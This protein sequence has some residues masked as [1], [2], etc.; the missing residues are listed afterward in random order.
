MPLFRNP[1]TGEVNNYEGNAALAASRA[2]YVPVGGGSVDVYT[3]AGRHTAVDIEDAASFDHSLPVV[4]VDPAQIEQQRYA[5]LE[6]E[7]LQE[8]HGGAGG[9]VG[10]FLE[11]GA[12]ALTLGGYGALNEAFGGDFEERAEA[13]PKAHVGGE[14]AGLLG[15]VLVPGGGEAAIGRAG[16]AGKALAKTPA[17]FVSGKAT[18]LAEHI[19]G[20]RGAAAGQALEGAAY[21]TG[22]TLSQA[23]I[24]D[25]QLT[26][27]A[28]FGEVGKNAL[29]GAGIGASGAALAKGL[30]KVGGRLERAGQGVDTPIL[31]IASSEGR[32]AT[33]SLAGTL[34]EVD[35]VAENS[36]AAIQG[37]AP[38][39]PFK[40]SLD[41]S[42]IPKGPLSLDDVD[43]T[44]ADIPLPVRPKAVDDLTDDAV[45]FVS[46]RTKADLQEVLD[47]GGDV[48]TAPAH[49]HKILKSVG[50]QVVDENSVMGALSKSE[51]KAIHRAYADA[52]EAVVF[53]RE[54]KTP[55]S[56]NKASRALDKY[57]DAVSGAAKK[58][59]MDVEA[60]LEVGRRSIVPASE[61][62]SK[63]ASSARRELARA[64]AAGVEA[65]AQ[66]YATP[67]TFNKPMKDFAP[68]IPPPTPKKPGLSDIPH[69]AVLGENLAAQRALAVEALGLK[70]GSLITAD[71]VRALL[72]KTPDEALIGLRR[73]DDY[74]DATRRTVEELGDARMLHRLDKS[75]EKL[76]EQIGD[77]T[78]GVKL[79]ELDRSVIATQMGSEALASAEFKTKVGERLHEMMTLTKVTT[80]K[81]P[82]GVTKKGVL[83]G[84]L[85]SA[86]ARAAA[87][88]GSRLGNQAA[89]GGIGGALLG[90]VGASTGFHVIRSLA[91]LVSG[92]SGRIKG[93]VGAVSRKGGKLMKASSKAVRPATV[94]AAWLIRESRWGYDPEGIKA[95]DAS[96]LRE[97]FRHRA[98]ELAKIAAN[99]AAAQ[100]KIHN[101]LTPLRKYAPGVADELEMLSISVPLYLADKMPK[102]P[103]NVMRWGK[104][105]W[106]PDDY[107]ILRWGEH[108]R[109]AVTPV[110]TFETMMETGYITPQAAEAVRTLHPQLFDKMQLE[111]FERADEL[112]TKLDHGGQVRVSLFFDVPVT[113]TMRP[114]FRAFMKERHALKAQTQAPTGPK[115]LGTSSGS[116]DAVDPYTGAQQLLK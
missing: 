62:A 36:L 70:K 43:Y 22:Q 95:P 89:G 98:E 33:R 82:K 47:A 66:P 44:S 23:Y 10:A 50:D 45:D 53:A 28:L 18:A 12:D 102:D 7:R 26:A 49:R 1:T 58:L 46:P 69:A 64:E 73:L 60:Q 79:S 116:A 31:D 30:A 11:G 75:V 39:R 71:A 74:I 21:A 103:G 19:G 3:P 84:L 41:E 59:G 9:Q 97:A 91:G 87:R 65:T 101:E 13:N 78:G 88:G 100:L 83:G 92:T 34:D 16:L 5:E 52:D 27:S 37:K 114:E 72:T 108:M 81:L 15:A 55:A 29:F 105:E 61:E 20:L 104:S 38:G 107:Q 77:L 68:P 115:N 2:G 85:S 4:G 54:A 96:T 32:K 93:A 94:T 63:A 110:E 8:E 14:V 24:Q 111:V 57:E 86:A 80:Q 76:S 112:K 113:S 99:P 109:G 40:T 106:R 67:P 48:T 56:V 17:G 90:G 35:N 6:D 25:E 42:A 51:V